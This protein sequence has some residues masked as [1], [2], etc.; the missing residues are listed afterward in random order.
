MICTPHQISIRWS[1]Q[2]E[3]HGWGMWHVALW[4]HLSWRC[5]LERRDAYRGLVGNL[6]C[7]QSLCSHCTDWSVLK[8]TL[9]STFHVTIQVCNKLTL[10]THTYHCILCSVLAT[11]ATHIQ[12]LDPSVHKSKMCTHDSTDWSSG[13]LTHIMLSLENLNVVTLVI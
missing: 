5:I 3:W 10:Q 4:M 6:R 8:Y 13:Y 12:N 7:R 1:N 11:G 9:Q 2:E